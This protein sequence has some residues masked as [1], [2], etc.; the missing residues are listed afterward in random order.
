[1]NERTKLLEA[2][3]AL[4]KMFGGFVPLVSIT[5]GSGLGYMVSLLEESKMCP[6]SN[7]PHCPTPG[8]TGHDGELWLGKLGGVP[9]VMLRGRVHL[10]EGYTVHEVVFLTRLMVMMGVRN[11]ILTHATGSVTRNL[12]PGDIVGVHSQIALTCPDPTSGQD[13]PLLGAE[14]SPVG[15]NV[16]HSGLLTLAK[17]CALAEQVSFHRGVSCWKF[18]RTY[19]SAA[20]GDA[21]ARLG[22]DVAT[23]STIPE[24]MA[25]AQMGA[26]VLDLA[27]V[28]DMV[29]N[30]R[31]TS[32]GEVSHNEVLEI[33]ELMKP[34][35]GRLVSRIVKE[36]GQLL[37]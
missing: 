14:F 3:G 8:A 33:V 18:G 12:E 2:K 29:A 20:E 37:T 23:M 13:T 7:I 24:V 10:Y 9:V 26:K 25:A 32:D 35:F 15:E 27:L 17:K 19:E 21:M 30:V 1:M 34:S 22:A 28:T 31:P 36:M 11:L 6:Y 16:F 4:E 5:L